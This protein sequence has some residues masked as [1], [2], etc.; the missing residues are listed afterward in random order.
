MVVGGVDECSE[1]VT[2]FEY[3]AAGFDVDCERGDDADP[4][5]ISVVVQVSGRWRFVGVPCW[6]VAHGYT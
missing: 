6:S 4:E 1:L 2:L 3:L 5:M